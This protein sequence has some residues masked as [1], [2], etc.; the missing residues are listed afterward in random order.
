MYQRCID[1]QTRP[2]MEPGDT[3]DRGEFFRNLKKK[4]VAKRYSKDD[5]NEPEYGFKLCP[6][7]WKDADHQRGPLS[8]NLRTCI[9]SEACSISLQSGAGEYYHVA[10][11]DIE[12]LNRCG[13]LTSAFVAQF[14]PEPPNQCHFEIVPLDG[15]VLK[16]MELGAHLDDPFPPANKLPAT[17]EEKVGAKS[18]YERYRSYIDIRR[19][20][21]HRDGSLH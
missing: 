13:F 19:W 16:W 6:K 21:R 2:D 15:T 1:Q 14:Q 11:I 17:P 18:A 20:V 9:H 3:T 4:H 8:V 5:D 10:L 7:H 12:V